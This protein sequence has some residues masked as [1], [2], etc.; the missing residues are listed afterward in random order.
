MDST[1]PVAPGFDARFI[2]DLGAKA[3]EIQQVAIPLGSLQD[4]GLPNTI[5]ALWDPQKSTL[6][7]VALEAEKYRL[8]PKRRQGTAKALTLEA[9][10]ALVDRHKTDDSVVFAD[11]NWRAPSFTGVIDYHRTESG[12]GAAFGRHRVLYDFPLS[13]EWKA[14]VEADGKAMSQ[15]DF[16]TFLEDRIADLSSPTTA[17]KIA[18]EGDF[19]TT[20]ATPAELIQLSRKMQVNVESKVVNAQTLQSGAGQIQW[21]E[22]H[23]GA[24]GNPITVPGIFLLNIAPFFMG[25]KERIPVRLRYRVKGTITWFFQIYR[26]DEHVTNRVRADLDIVAKRTARPVFEGAPEMQAA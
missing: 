19:S 7:S 17:E 13:E 26:P 4:E 12:G 21:E 18:L 23:K 25:E 14:W 5:P 6:I 9:F 1:I 2:A 22:Q 11:T 24:D 8:A 16:A 20:I 10:I 15:V 3:A